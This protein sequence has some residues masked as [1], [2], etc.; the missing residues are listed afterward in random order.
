MPM[1]RYV[2]GHWTFPRRSPWNLVG[3]QLLFQNGIHGILPRVQ[4]RRLG[5][6]LPPFPSSRAAAVVVASDVCCCCCCCMNANA[7]CLLLLPLRRCHLLLLLLPRLLLHAPPPCARPSSHHR[8]PPAI[9]ILSGRKGLLP[10]DSA[11]APSAP[12]PTIPST[13]EARRSASRRRSPPGAS[14]TELRAGPCTWT[15]VQLSY[16]AATV[17]M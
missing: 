11:L 17:R 15:S 16:V 4:V 3:I 13:A 1:T 12:A 2:P 10:P 6:L 9:S 7:A 14:R 8:L 5:G